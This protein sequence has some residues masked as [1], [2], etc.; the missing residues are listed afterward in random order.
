MKIILGSSSRFRQEMLSQMGYQFSIV[1]PDIDEKSI[2]DTNPRKLVMAIALAKAEAILSKIPEPAII[3]TADQV[4]L[5]K[6]EIREKP[7]SEEEARNFL[8]S[9]GESPIET[10]NAVVATN[11]KTGK[12]SSGTDS[13]RIFLRP[14]PE[15]TINSLI[16]E[17]IIFH[18][19][20]GLRLEDPLMQPFIIEIKGSQ[21]SLMGLPKE[22]TRSLIEKVQE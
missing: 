4:V 10:I 22:L 8:S 9:Y 16:Q 5:F 2:R 19:A 1:S 14:I 12:Q 13:T 17:G 7:T 6:G 11:S 15:E 21:D 3:I 18:C 20:G